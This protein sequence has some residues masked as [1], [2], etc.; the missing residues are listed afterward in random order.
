MSGIS[1]DILS[2][3]T[4]GKFSK[5]AC[6]STQTEAEV[7]IKRELLLTYEKA[8]IPIHCNEF[9]TSANIELKMLEL[10]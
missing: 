10:A 6:K 4:R 5:S 2:S 8:I 7:L 9:K 3:L 1:S